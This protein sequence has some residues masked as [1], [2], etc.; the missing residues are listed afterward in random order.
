MAHTSSADLST[1]LTTAY[2][3]WSRLEG[4][5]LGASNTDINDD[6]GTTEMWNIIPESSN[7]DEAESNDETEDENSSLENTMADTN[8]NNNNN[9]DGNENNNNNNNNNNNRNSAFYDRA[10]IYLSSLFDATAFL[11]VSFII[12]KVFS[13]TFNISTFSNDISIDIRNYVNLPANILYNNNLTLL[14]DGEAESRSMDDNPYSILRLA[15]CFFDSLQVHGYPE[16]SFFKPFNLTC[17]LTYNTSDSDGITN[18]TIRDNATLKIIQQATE[19]AKHDFRLISV[20][21]TTNISEHSA[22]DDTK[23]II[24]N[25]QGYVVLNSLLFKISNALVHKIPWFCRIV[26]ASVL[27]ATALLIYF[28]Y[29][30]ISSFYLFSCFVFFSISMYYLVSKKFLDLA[31]H[32]VNLLENDSDGIF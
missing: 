5:P 21:R 20:V 12:L 16:Y 25:Q 19:L 4:E 26:P 10:V 15:E 2:D 6:S 7:S 3:E 27:R 9:D 1:D 22:S 31:S 8:I 14:Y 23:D 13:F 17:L 18:F 32:V 28:I 11:F 29:G 24:Q 30:C